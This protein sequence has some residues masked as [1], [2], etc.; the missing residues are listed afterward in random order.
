MQALIAAGVAGGGLAAAG[1]LLAW[2]T[3]RSRNH[4]TIGPGTKT[5]GGAPGQLRTPRRAHRRVWLRGEQRWRAGAALAAG[6][7]TALATGWP[8]AA[9]VAAAAGWWLPPML[10]GDH[11]AQAARQRVEAIASWADELRDV[12]SAAAGLR[13]ALLAT[14]STAP[15]AIRPAVQTLAARIRSGQRL[16]DALR[17]FAAEVDDPLADLVAAALIHAAAHQA[18]QVGPLLGRLA[19][20]ARAHA[21]AAARIATARAASR[22]T[23]RIIT[24]TVLSGVVLLAVSDRAFLA[25]YHTAAGQAVLL[26]IG[27]V[28]AVGLAWIRRL[29]EPPTPPRPLTLAAPPHT[30]PYPSSPTAPAADSGSGAPT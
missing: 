9:V 12:L 27:A 10:G 25:P 30:G 2:P 23:L 20:T 22:T 18:R 17:G 4:P 3:T 5:G 24:G 29:A 28:F 8:A 7:V 6:V 1:V 14:T 21:D 16:P 13:Q 19:D 15:D 26:A 11:A